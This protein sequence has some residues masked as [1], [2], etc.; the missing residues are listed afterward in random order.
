MVKPLENHLLATPGR[1]G[2]CAYDITRV[3]ASNGVW[4]EARESQNRVLI[5]ADVSPAVGTTA[6][7][8]QA[9]LVRLSPRTSRCDSKVV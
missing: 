7:G 2:V 9:H 1:T 4:A 5:R 6:I 8:K 3:T